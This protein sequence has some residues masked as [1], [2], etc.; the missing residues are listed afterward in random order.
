MTIRWGIL[1]TGNIAN[2]VASDLQLLPDA[3]IA[4]VGSRAQE[5]ADA[6]GDEFAIP[7]RFDSYEALVTKADVDVVHVAS[8][9]PYHVGHATLAL[10]AGCAVLCE[11][12]LALNADGAA[13]LIA[14]AREQDEFLM[15]GMWTR[16][17]PVM[18][19]VRRVVADELGTVQVLRADI[20]FHQPFDPEHRVFN[21]ALGGG[22]LLDLGVYP[23]ALAFEL[24]GPPDDV[25]SS[26]VLGDTGVDEQCAVVFQYDDGM[27]AVWQA[28]VRADAGRTCAIAG[29]GGRLQGRRAWWKGAP[30]DLTRAD[31]STETFARPFEGNG[32]QFEAAHVMRCLRKGK[33][34]SPVMP[35][36]ESHALLQTADALRQEWGVTYPGEG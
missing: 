2:L 7:Q 30:F 28:S 4:A 23:I 13:R 12:P 6:F 36:D 34:E 24:F 15:E 27:Q 3:E 14:T 33:T 16:F 5:R 20:G 8:P 29:P 26:V 10:E 35:L 1:G 22:A 19:D 32:Y 17:L 21:P 31:G 9:H 11:K 25:T 18:D